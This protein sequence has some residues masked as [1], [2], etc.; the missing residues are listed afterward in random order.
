MG[1]DMYLESMPKVKGYS[2]E[3][4]IELD[5]KICEFDSLNSMYCEC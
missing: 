4:L 2:F 1:L 5:N 3:Q